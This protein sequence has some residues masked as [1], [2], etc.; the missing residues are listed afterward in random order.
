MLKFHFLDQVF[1]QTQMGKC[2]S[3]SPFVFGQKCNLKIKEGLGAE[4]AFSFFME[5]FFYYLFCFIKFNL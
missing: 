3:P 4:M 1:I 5:F 2:M